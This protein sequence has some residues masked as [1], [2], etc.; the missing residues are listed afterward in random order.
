MTHYSAAGI[1]N[2]ISAAEKVC[3][4]ASRKCPALAIVRSG[5][6][7]QVPETSGGK[8]GSRTLDPG[9]MS[10]A[11]WKVARTLSAVGASLCESMRNLGGI[12]EA[13]DR[14]ERFAWSHLPNSET[15]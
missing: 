10:T 7:P 15:A 12:R 2:L 9:I 3:E 4:L 14:I 11:L 8:G 6:A 5:G 13:T 1:G